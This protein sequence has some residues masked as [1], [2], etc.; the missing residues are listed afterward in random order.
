M[1]LVDRRSRHLW[2]KTSYSPRHFRFCSKREKKHSTLICSCRCSS[3]MDERSVCTF[4]RCWMET[5]SLNVTR[6]WLNSIVSQNNTAVCLSYKTFNMSRERRVTDRHRSVSR[7]PPLNND[8]ETNTVPSR[9]WGVSV[10]FIRRRSRTVANTSRHSSNDDRSNCS[11][12]R[13][14][15]INV[16]LR[17]TPALQWTNLGREDSRPIKRMKS[18]KALPSF[19]TQWLFRSLNA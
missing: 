6:V 17:P 12:N 8:R 18:I 9:D 3:V 19:G 7:I 14:S 10:F 11:N 5:F 4:I 1:F 15:A 13:S 2:Y 16:P